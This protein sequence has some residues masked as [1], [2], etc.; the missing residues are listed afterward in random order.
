MQQIKPGGHVTSPVKQVPFGRSQSGVGF[1]NGHSF[2]S[3]PVFTMESGEVNSLE[4]TVK[5]I[6]IS[7]CI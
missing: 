5:N 6:I 1:K 2:F 4:Q 7:N 3:L